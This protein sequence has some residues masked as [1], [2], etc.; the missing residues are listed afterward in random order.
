MIPSGVFLI[1]MLA[2]D[3]VLLHLWTNS[4]IEAQRLLVVGA[5]GLCAGA[6][7][8]F[9]DGLLPARAGKWVAVGAATILAVLYIAELLINVYFQNFMPL[10]MMLAGGAGVAG[11]FMRDVFH[12]IVT[13]ILHIAAMLL[14]IV[15]YAVLADCGRVG[16]QLRMVLLGAVAGL[17]GLSIILVCTVG[18]Y[19]AGLMTTYNFD[20][21]VR[22]YGLSMALPLEIY[23][24]L[25]GAERG[26]QFELQEQEP[27]E[28]TTAP[29]EPPATQAQA[30]TGET[31]ETEAATEPP[32]E[33]MPH[34]LALD[35]AELAEEEPYNAI[36]K[37]HRY[38]DSLTPSMENEYT[39]MFEGKNLILITAEAFTKEFIDQELTPALYRMMT[40]GI[41]FTDY[42]QPGWGAGTTGGEFSNVVGIMPYGGKCMEEAAQQDLFLTI[43]HQLQKAGYS[44]AA[45]HN[46]SYTY[47]SRHLTHKKLGY[48]IF[49]GYGNGMEKGVK[50]QWPQSDEEMFRYTIPQWMES[51]EPF[52]LYYMTVSGHSTYSQ[53]ENAMSRKH[54]EEVADLPYNETVKCYIAANL[55]LEASMAYL[56]EALEEAGIADDTVVVISA[57]H[58]PYGLNA[59][60]L[61]NYFGEDTT[62]EMVR[63]RNALIIWSGCL[64]DQDI[65]VD[66]P[67]YSLDIL[68]TLSNLFGVEYDSRLLP[69]R[70]VFSDAEPLVFWT[71][72]SWKT[73]KGTYNNSTRTFTPNEGVEVEEGYVKRISSRV[74]NIYTY[75]RTVQQNDYFNYVS[76]ALEEAESM[77]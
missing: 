64:E 20:G 14:P 50:K 69:G 53:K 52:S 5:F 46:N 25:T 59:A 47:Y 18:D 65:V 51:E 10:S 39:G 34:V 12:L 68:P 62:D 6:L 15:A 4:A 21:T 61:N 8:A 32:A 60:N 44:S 37:M 2:Y 36:A 16:W 27:V 42:Y 28:E 72:F 54:Y 1:V 33:P 77:A 26:P 41:Y 66:T 56:I 23:E 70:D 76:K 58:Y 74:T 75:C 22:S 9:L 3:E 17:Y 45:Y 38:V 43:G 29:T 71:D 57:D 19:A 11:T 73:D 7:F 31:E 63:D 67:V 24:T 35:F 55:E 30:A 49:M 48:D 40:E 13:H